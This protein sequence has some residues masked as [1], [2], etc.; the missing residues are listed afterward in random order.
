MSQETDISWQVLRRIAQ[1]WGGESAEL[2]EVTPLD[3]GS[4]ST[5]L[6]LSLLDGRK[7]VLKI[8]PHRVDRSYVNEAHQLQLM[9]AA[10]LPVP[11]VYSAKVGSLDD[12]FSF[13]LM[14]FVDGV[15]LSQARKLCTP[16][17]FATLQAHLAELMLKLHGISGEAYARVEK[18]PTFPAF[19]AWPEFYRNVFEPIWVEVSK[20]PL[21][22]LKY[23]KLMGKLHDRL[24]RHLAHCDAPRLVHW[25]LWASNLLARPNEAGEWKIVAILDP[26]CKFA[27][28][29]AELAYMS[30][31]QTAT[32]EFMKTYQKHQRL[33]DEYHRV[34]KP[35]YQTYFL[36]NHVHRFGKEYVKPLVMTLDKLAPVV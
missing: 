23:R 15:D 33:P 26:N 12:P 6:A 24:D 9:D 3:G 8:S 10:G 29:E 4:I 32:S 30:L 16:E 28:T 20:S 14:E 17:Q 31:F 25:D 27:D 2:S 21:L 11:R 18:E 22:E 34:R 19:D 7:S 36:M 35:I 13:I 1:D 5:T